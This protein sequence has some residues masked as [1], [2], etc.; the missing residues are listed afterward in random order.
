MIF[1]LSVTVSCHPVVKDVNSKI[2]VVFVCGAGRSGT[3]LV[4]DLLHLH[5]DLASLYETDFVTSLLQEVSELPKFE[6]ECVSKKGVTALSQHVR[7]I[8]SAWQDRCRDYNPREDKG[9][10]ESYLHGAMYWGQSP[11]EFRELLARRTDILCR[12]LRHQPPFQALKRFCDSIF[13]EHAR[14]EGKRVVVNKTPNYGSV[15]H[16]LAKMYPEAKV[17]HCIRDGRD[18]ACS[19]VERRA[20]GEGNL[21]D[22]VIFWK[23]QVVAGLN[24]GHNNMQRYREVYYESLVA[25]CHLEL[26]QVLEFLEVQ[27]LADQM[28][29]K[30][31]NGRIC[32]KRVGR[33]R[34][35][36][37]RAIASLEKEA[38]ALLVKLGYSTV[39]SRRADSAKARAERAC[40]AKAAV[41]EKE[42]AATAHAA[43]ACMANSACRKEAQGAE[44]LSTETALPSRKDKALQPCAPITCLCLGP[45]ASEILLGA[46]LEDGVVLVND[47][48]LQ[49]TETPRR[50]N[51]EL[52]RLTLTSLRSRF[53]LQA[54]RKAVTSMCFGPSLKELLSSSSDGS[55]CIAE[56]DSGSLLKKFTTSNIVFVV[57]ELPWLP[58]RFVTIA[59]P[60]DV[61][62][63]HCAHLRCNSHVGL[64]LGRTTTL[65]KLRLRSAITVLAIDDWSGCLLVGNSRGEVLRVHTALK[66]G[67]LANELSAS[68]RLYALPK[69]NLASCGIASM[70]FVPPTRSTRSR[71]LLVG[72]EDGA[73]MMAQC[74]Y[75][76]EPSASGGSRKLIRIVVRRRVELPSVLWSFRIE[77]DQRQASWPCSTS[78]SSKEAGGI[79][80][81]DD[82][83]PP[84]HLAGNSEGSLLATWVDNNVTLW[85]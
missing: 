44:P 57:L 22:A 15:L 60:R 43:K 17:L 51:R 68:V 62:G 5:K 26:S 33:Y 69:H 30:Y 54:H 41:T 73:L 46:G 71:R 10:H 27:N 47:G 18:V 80:E 20:W 72:Q 37:P 55:V 34:E 81:R 16:L 1:L 19:R 32:H 56:L 23:G 24:W 67:S 6:T 11:L 83:P 50:R 78:C 35:L 77:G 38:G 48:V 52:V 79:R 76:S 31:S 70:A 7:K 59:T 74:T 84:K 39:N 25:D 29:E 21:L 9:S 13:Q 58:G 3:T 75:S 61:S 65:S 40:A 8:V 45:H 2:V 12:D 49:S 36:Q 64:P 63:Q 42:R 53:R 14:R 85:A 82:L 4:A 66:N 28:L